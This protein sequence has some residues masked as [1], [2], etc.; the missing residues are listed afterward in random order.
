M[1]ADNFLVTIPA[2]GGKIALYE[3]SASDSWTSLDNPAERHI[4]CRYIHDEYKDSLLGV[5]DDEAA[6]DAFAAS[7]MQTHIVEYGLKY[8]HLKNSHDYVS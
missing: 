8:F 5:F 3:V 1:S 2:K 4:A 6:V 7:Y